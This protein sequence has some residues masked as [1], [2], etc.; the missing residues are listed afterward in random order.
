MGRFK[1]CL[2]GSPQRPVLELEASDVA[3]L[4]HWLARARYIEG[5]MVEIDGEQT[6]CEVLIPA[7]RIQMIFGWHE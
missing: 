6:D 3:E 4:H 7:N 1:F 2:I 5:R